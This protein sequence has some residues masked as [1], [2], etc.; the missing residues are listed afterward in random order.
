MWFVGLT[1]HVL[2]AGLDNSE[3]IFFVMLDGLFPTI[4]SAIFLAAVLSA[5]MSTAD[6]QLLSAAAAIAHDLGLGGRNSTTL[7][8][9]SRLTIVALVMASVIVAIYLPEKIFSRVL[10]AWM[11]LGAAFGP[12]LFARM[13]GVGVRPMGVIISILVGFVLTCLLYTS[14]SPRDLSTS[15]MPSSA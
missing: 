11:A 3:Q 8:F 2:H 5:I 10:F 9:V 13:A 15:R 12:T 7:L 1:G 14:P 6:S 4:I